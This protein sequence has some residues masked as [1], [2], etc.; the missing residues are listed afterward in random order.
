MSLPFTSS[1]IAS[2]IFSVPTPYRDR[3]PP[4]AALQRPGDRP[5]AQPDHSAAGLVRAAHLVQPQQLTTG[6]QVGTGHEPHDRV[7][8]RLR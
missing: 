8:I 1:V 4:A 3:L 2:M 7:E 6:G 5:R